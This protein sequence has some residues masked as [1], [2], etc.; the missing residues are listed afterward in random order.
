MYLC[1]QVDMAVKK[2]SKYLC[3]ARLTSH[4]AL[5]Q[6]QR[7]QRREKKKLQSSPEKPQNGHSGPDTGQMESMA[8]YS[9][10]VAH[11]GEE[12]KGGGDEMQLSLAESFLLGKIQCCGSGMLIPE[13]IFFL[14]GS[15]VDKI[16]DPDLHKRIYVI[17]TQKTETM[18]TKFSK[19]RSGITSRIP[20]PGSG[21]FPPDFW[22]QGSKKLRIPDP[23]PQNW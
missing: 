14:P 9:E 1:L 23:D 18:D 10:A 20:D 16:P 22:I 4:H 21:F 3:S 11:T 2:E 15:R 5:W 12:T 6:H 8:K 19:I 7:K 17:L 13:P